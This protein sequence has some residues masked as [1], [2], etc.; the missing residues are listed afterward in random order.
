MK[1][2]TMTNLCY[3]SRGTDVKT[4]ALEA[5]RRLFD[6]GF[7]NQDLFLCGLI[8]PAHHC[9]FSGDNWK[10]EA[11]ELKKLASALGINFHQCHL[12]YYPNKH[13][14]DNN[15]EFNRFFWNMFDRGIEICELLGIRCAVVHPFRA[16]DVDRQDLA[17]HVA[18]NRRLYGPHAQKAARSWIRFAFENMKP[19]STFGSCAEDLTAITEEF[20]EESSGICW[21]VGHGQ[22]TYGDDQ[23]GAVEQLG[24]RIIALHVH[25]NHGEK[26][27]HYPPFIGSIRWEPLMQALKQ[28]GYQGYLNFEIAT[29][30]NLPDQL[31]D[32]L[33]RYCAKAGDALV[34][35]FEEARP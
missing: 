31:R 18:E 2:S 6:A 20:R 24:G 12:P 13:Y 32:D 14:D 33:A 26:D 5:S 34:A 22:L 23:T 16:A 9:S 17:A 3:S 10:E 8:R 28:A 1:V 15:E 4:P 35:L 7:I 21:D 29:N 27:D 19:A 11:L 25:D 30:R